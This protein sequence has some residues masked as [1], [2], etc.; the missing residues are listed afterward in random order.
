MRR[1]WRTGRLS[2]GK[3][4]P[5]RLP[6]TRAQPRDHD[7]GSGSG[8]P[9]LRVFITLE[10]GLKPSNSS[11]LSQPSTRKGSLPHCC[12]DAL[13]RTKP[14]WRAE[15]LPG[16][17]S[18]NLWR[19]PGSLLGLQGG[20]GACPGK[21]P[22]VPWL[23]LSLRPCELPTS[24]NPLP[25]VQLHRSLILKTPQHRHSQ[26]S[27]RKGSRSGTSAW[28]QGAESTLASDWTG[29]VED[30]RLSCGPHR[31]K[32]SQLG[33]PGLTAHTLGGSPQSC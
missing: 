3:G 23:K 21:Q 29:H 11:R 16:L 5:A 6:S 17:G 19:A 33:G 32:F 4:P 15:A 10:L 7:R 31:P 8:G 28:P 12:G 1:G 26:Y 27:L 20:G 2:S 25:Q 14:K 30:A 13:L 24:F 9:G 22:G 18:R